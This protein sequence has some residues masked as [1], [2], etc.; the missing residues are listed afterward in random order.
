MKMKK[1]M[2]EII[3]TVLSLIALIPSIQI[4]RGFKLLFVFRLGKVVR[5]WHMQRHYPKF[6]RLSGL[7]KLEHRFWV[8]RRDKTSLP[9]ESNAH[10][11]KP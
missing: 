11:A 1:V 10:S 6:G 9:K 8:D 3:V 7:F 2:A 4:L 5:C